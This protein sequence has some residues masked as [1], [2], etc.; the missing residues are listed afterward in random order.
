[1]PA[2][3]GDPLRIRVV[4]GVVLGIALAVG[5]GGQPAAAMQP[6]PP[7]TWDEVLYRVELGGETSPCTNVEYTY[8][9]NVAKYYGYD[10]GSRRTYVPQGNVTATVTI[11]V[12][13]RTASGRTRLFGGTSF[14][15]RFTDAD[16][17]T[18]TATGSGVPI[19]P[20]SSLMAR[21]E[22]ATMVVTAKSCD[23][24]LSTLSIWYH[25]P[26]GF[27]PWVGGITGPVRL[28]PNAAG[29]YQATTTLSTFA[30]AAPR[31]GC[32]ATF[33]VEDVEAEITG[34]VNFAN[35]FIFVISWSDG[36]SRAKVVCGPVSSTSREDTFSLDLTTGRLPA[37][38]PSGT[39]VG[40]EAPHVLHA[41]SDVNGITYVILTPVP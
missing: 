22:P 38:P 31:D 18:I 21:I 29:K 14:P 33:D 2:K 23:F 30:I 9:V 16:T 19:I 17:Y 36:T 28:H 35:S 40:R 7:G 41:S 3:R 25:L 20:G 15:A 32:V 1:M 5:G 26:D 39:S 10:N 8:T 12:A 37:S 24:D 13:G 27:K 6:N 34:A 4:L 11:D